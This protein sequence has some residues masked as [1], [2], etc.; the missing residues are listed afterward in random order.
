LITQ[1]VPVNLLKGWIK[2]VANVNPV[3]ALLETGRGFISGEAT[4]VV[5]AFAAAAALGALF[6]VWALRG[7]RSAETAG[8]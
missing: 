6:L 2:A 1:Y 5:I 4:D 7:M 8:G 3:S